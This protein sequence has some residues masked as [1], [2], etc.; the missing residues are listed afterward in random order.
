MDEIEVEE[1]A[2]ALKGK[3]IYLKATVRELSVSFD[4]METR[5]SIEATILNS[6]YMRLNKLPLSGNLKVILR[7][8]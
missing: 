3:K 7:E 5:L 6:D 2:D 8:E 1:L 4:P